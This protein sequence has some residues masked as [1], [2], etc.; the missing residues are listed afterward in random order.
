MSEPII[1]GL[2]HWDYLVIVFYFV[3][4]IGIG[5]LFRMMNKNASDYFRGGG[6]MLWWMAGMS[7]IMCALSTW[8][9]TGAAAKTY[10]SG[11]LLPS[12]WMISGFCTLP[13][14][15]WMAPRFR[16]SRVITSIEA[17]FRRYGFGT[18][19]FY[20]YLVLPMGIFW[21]GVGLNTV[22]VFMSAALGLDMTLTLIALGGIVTFMSML[23]GQWAVA[24]SDFV[25]G[26]IM[27][28]IVFV[29]IYFSVNLP[30]IGGIT[31]LVHSLPSRHF[32]FDDGA[33]GGI[34]TL[35]VVSL[36]IMSIL[37]SMDMQGEGS[38]Y[39]LVK[40]GKHARGIVLMRLFMLAIVPVAVLMQ[41]PAMCAATIFPNMAEV[42]PNLKVPQ[43]GA[44]VAMA[45]KTLPQ[46]LIG[47]MI[48]GMFA[49]SMSTM[50]TSLNR[51]SGYFI[52]NIY[53][54]YIN[55]H[56]SEKKQL[57][58][59]QIFTCLF[60]VLM[61]LVAISFDTLR[62]INLFDIFQLLNSMILVPSM[63]PIS[64]GMVY[65]NTPGWTGWST[66]LVGMTAGAIAK[67]FY[68]PELIQ[69]LMGYT[70]QLNARE[71]IDTQFIFVF[72]FVLASGNGWFFLTSLWYHQSSPD[73]Q[74]RVEALFKDMRTPINHRTEDVV[75]QDAIQFK[76]VGVMCM[77]FGAFTL[78][79]I[80]IPNP[81]HGRMAFLFIGSVIFT[82]GLILWF[83]YLRK[84]RKIPTDIEQP[85]QD[86]R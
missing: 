67:L 50:D 65:K 47:F 83:A 73:H 32:D 54:K 35:W 82:I 61:I 12:V 29:V 79:C 24:A 23:G 16:Q 42:F 41:I 31:N 69:H 2:T 43:E 14:L 80:A 60:G 25:Q 11:F 55:P 4:I 62:N 15:W 27:F 39:L 78:A 66:V 10:E 63:I 71:I 46:G 59:G 34:V 77:A 81:Y 45:F 26:L 86:N 74:E 17:V 18:E 49:A 5:G 22:A 72:S 44:F 21:G 70:Q 3:F 51:N 9:F 38:K 48:C 64:L 20:A 57:S 56:A 58:M 40:D 33:H 68:S 13:I 19:Q 53:I 8:S 28:L 75:N 52:R 37:G 30:E 85:I 7:A 36:I 1:R 76:L 84:I 6:N